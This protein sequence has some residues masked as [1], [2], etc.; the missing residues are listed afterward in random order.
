MNPIEECDDFL[1]VASSSILKKRSRSCKDVEDDDAAL[2]CPICLEEMVNSGSRCISSIKC[3]HLF[4]ESCILDWYIQEIK[5]NERAKCPSCKSPFKKPDV[6]RLVTSRLIVH[7]VSELE[8]VKKELEHE[9]RQNVELERK[10]ARSEMALAQCRRWLLEGSKENEALKALMMKSKSNLCE[11]IKTTAT[12]FTRRVF[13]PIHTPSFPVEMTGRSVAL[14]WKEEMAI[15][16]VGNEKKKFGIQKVS[17]I[18]S[19]S[20]DFFTVH[21]KHIRD[22]KCSPYQPSLVLTTSMDRAL[23]ITCAK[24]KHIIQQYTLERPGWAC[25]FDDSHSNYL[26]CGLN[27]NVVM[28]YDIRKTNATLHRLPGNSTCFPIHSIDVATNK[29][30]AKFI[31]CSNTMESYF[32]DMSDPANPVLQRISGYNPYSLSLDS[33]ETLL[34]SYRRSKHAEHGAGTKHTL[35]TVQD[36]GTNPLWSIESPHPQVPLARTHFFKQAG[37]EEFLV[38]FSKD[39][40]L[41]I[42]SREGEVEQFDVKSSVLDVKSKCIGPTRFL[43][44]VTEQK[45]HLYKYE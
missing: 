24:N 6:R 28:V 36:S 11:K 22:V 13:H 17:L 21:E 27:N 35:Y 29:S 14:N 18:D 34:V 4:C 30:G 9:K 20:I 26:Y 10:L 23:K 33:N 43:A 5:K 19:S 25:S 44:A 39:Q 42:N 8:R 40:T 2:T 1:P 38:C 16:S 3:G 12:L 32:W 31:F 7:D 41:S 45:L 15:T 37:N